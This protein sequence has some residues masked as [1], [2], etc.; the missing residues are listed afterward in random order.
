MDEPDY[1]ACFGK[2]IEDYRARRF[3]EAHEHWEVIWRDEPDAARKRFVQGLILVA[4][5]MHKLYVMKNAAGATRLLERALDR[6]SDCPD[7]NEGIAV[8]RLRGEARQAIDRL[9]GAAPNDPSPDDL[10]P[11]IGP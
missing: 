6:L 8:D 1:A 4:A 3:Y 9:R 7:R 10:A 5:A 11:A 2:G